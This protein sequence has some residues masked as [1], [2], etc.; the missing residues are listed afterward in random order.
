MVA[1]NAGG[2]T[3]ADINVL[4]PIA[5]S[6]EDLGLLLGLMLRRDGPLVAN[7]E[8]ASKDAKSLRVATWLDYPF[9]A[10]DAA[11]RAVTNSA[12]NALEASGVAVDR[13]ARPDIDPDEASRLGFSLATAQSSPNTKNEDKRSALTTALMSHRHRSDANT[14]QNRFAATGRGSSTVTTRFCCRSP[15]CRHLHLIGTVISPVD[16]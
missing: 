8:P 11:V 15:S 6:A 5:R 3:E 16:H 14:K 1:L 10:L 2:T 9:C 13:A 12:V 7:I 4:G